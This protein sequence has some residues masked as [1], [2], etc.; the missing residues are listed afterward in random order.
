MG[1]P[2]ISKL[3]NFV[4]SPSGDLG[5]AIRA[6]VVSIDDVAASLADLAAGAR[7]G[8][9]REDEIVIFDS[10][11][12]VVQDVAAAAAAYDAVRTRNAGCP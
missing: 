5:H 9:T 7:P 10:T 11:G 12:T 6:G 1:T 2:K 4:D 3:S 8:R